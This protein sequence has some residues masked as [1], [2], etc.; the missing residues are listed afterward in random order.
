MVIWLVLLHAD[1]AASLE[2]AAEMTARLAV[3]IEDDLDFRG[4]V[5]AVL[6]AAG[7]TVQ[8]EATGAGGI[9]SARELR[10]DLIVLDF[11]LPDLNGLQVALRIRE[12]TDAHILALTGR[13]D[14]E[15]AML[16][17]GVDEFLAKPFSVREL[18]DRVTT[19]LGMG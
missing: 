17:A 18:R 10:P 13:A 16:A 6:S 4:L 5:A 19:A 1:A 11:G 9:A 14:M 3:V 7:I 15:D 12:F 2:G 8:T